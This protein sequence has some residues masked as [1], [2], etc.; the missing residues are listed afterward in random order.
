VRNEQLRLSKKVEFT[1]MPQVSDHVNVNANLQPNQLIFFF[2]LSISAT[3]N[4]KALPSSSRDFEPWENGQKKKKGGG[5]EGSSG[6]GC[7]AGAKTKRQE[8][9]SVAELVDHPNE[10]KIER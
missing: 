8:E 6:G 5:W 9:E 2:S 3:T 4:S 7:V 10:Q 1:K